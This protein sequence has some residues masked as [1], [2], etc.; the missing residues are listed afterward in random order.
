MN[1]LAVDVRAEQLLAQ[2]AGASDRFVADQAKAVDRLSIEIQTLV[3]ANKLSGQVLHVRTGTL[4]RSINR[5]V[6]TRDN[7]VMGEVGTNVVY[8]AI[9][10]YGFDGSVDVRAHTRQ[11][12]G[13]GSANVRAYVMRMRMPERS[14]LRSTLAEEADRIRETLRQAALR[15]LSNIGD[16]RA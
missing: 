12:A 2:L 11:L 13:G 10:E 3:K 6:M 5:K 4:R 14:Y 9:H 7:S 1:D 8:G 15:S 16:T